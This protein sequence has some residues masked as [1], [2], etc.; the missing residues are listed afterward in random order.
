M[1]CCASLL[2]GSIR[3]T[4]SYAS[5]AS[6]ELGNPLLRIEIGRI[7]TDDLLIDVERLFGLTFLK[8]MFAE[9]QV[10]LNR[11]AQ[12]STFGIQVTQMPVHVI[13]VGIEF[14]DFLVGGDRLEGCPLT[15]ESIGGLN[16]TGDRVSGRITLQLQFADRIV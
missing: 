12:Q 14:K 5:L 7:L 6:A 15:T 13:A 16:E 4:D 11:A 3:N 10:V 9:G 2:A 8:V 1:N